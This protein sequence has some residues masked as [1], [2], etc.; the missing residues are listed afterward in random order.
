[1][2]DLLQRWRMLA[3]GADELGEA[4]IRAWDEPHRRYH[5]RGHL[6][7][8]LDEADRRA[9]LIREPTFVGYSI[10]F[11]DAIYEPG[12]PDNETRSA[13]WAREALKADP[14][15]ASRVADVIEQTK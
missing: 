10:W 3:G 14:N 5:D 8:L 9:R 2:A 1:M 11:H 15:L 12:R 6:T 7:W 13:D 4:L